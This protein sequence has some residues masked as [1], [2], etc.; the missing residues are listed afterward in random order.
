MT[1]N[2]IGEKVNALLSTGITNRLFI[3]KLIPDMGNRLLFCFRNSIF[4]IYLNTGLKRIDC[5]FTFPLF[6]KLL[7]IEK[8][9]L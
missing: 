8:N 6:A 2:P 7:L 9:D 5:I 1:P 4:E 3:W